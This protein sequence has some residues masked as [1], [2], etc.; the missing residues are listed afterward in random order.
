MFE[1][2]RNFNLSLKKDYKRNSLTWIKLRLNSTILQI[3]IL[4]NLQVCQSRI[5]NACPQNSF[6]VMLFDFF[7]FFFANK[8]T[9]KRGNIYGNW[10]IYD[11]D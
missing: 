1:Q 8:T 7:F 11:D 4:L 3:L 2:V 5:F 9:G 6:I 10:F